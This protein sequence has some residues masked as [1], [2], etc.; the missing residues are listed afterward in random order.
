MKLYIWIKTGVIDKSIKDTL[1]P[2]LDMLLHGA[3]LLKK[4]KKSIYNSLCN[5]LNKDQAFCEKT[6]ANNKVYDW[7]N[8]FF[9]ETVK[10]NKT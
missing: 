7:L 10:F 5:V 4:D 2:T 1:Q 8:S 9:F 3:C 6:A